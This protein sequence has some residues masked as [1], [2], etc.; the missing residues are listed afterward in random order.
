MTIDEALFLFEDI[1][2]DYIVGWANLDP[3]LKDEM[4]GRWAALIKRM[5]GELNPNIVLAYQVPDDAPASLTV[6]D[7]KLIKSVMSDLS[8]KVDAIQAAQSN[9]IK[10]I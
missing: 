5:I 7:F 8:S 2:D 10:G 4:K 3:V 9:P 1:T 6:A